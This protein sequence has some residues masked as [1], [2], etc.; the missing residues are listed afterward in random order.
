MV[1]LLKWWLLPLEIIEQSGHCWHVAVVYATVW[2]R[3]SVIVW[4]RCNVCQD[5]PEDY[6]VQVW[7]QVQSMLGSGRG[8][9]CAH[10]ATAVVYA[11]F[12][13][14]CNVIGWQQLQC[15]P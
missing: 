1:R 4:Q 7:Q 15:M 10:V 12:W 2:Q 13:Q 6:I 9:D 8:L 14:R 3:C 11:T 5:L